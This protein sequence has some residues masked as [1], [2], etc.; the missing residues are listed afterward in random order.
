MKNFFAA[1]DHFFFANI[2]ARGFGLMRMAWATVTG[3][4]FFFQWKS[5]GY[6]YGNAGLL[7]GGTLHTVVRSTM[8]FTLLD[9]VQEPNAVFALY[10]LML[11]CLLCTAIG[12]LPRIMM[13]ASTLLVFS[14]H[15]G[16]PLLLGGGDTVLRTVGFILCIAPT[17]DA[18]SLTRALR[19]WPQWKK[20]KKLPHSDT[21]S[22]WPYRLLL[23]QLIIIY[24]TSL[25]YKLLGTTWVQGSAVGLSLMHPVFSRFPEHIGPLLATSWIVNY[26]SLLWE[27]AWLLLLI[28]RPM[29]HLMIPKF[30]ER[31]S[32]KRFVML[33]GIVYHGMII[34][35]MDAG[36]F[37]FAIFA[38]YCGL[39]LAEDFG[40][41]KKNTCD[42]KLVSCNSITVLY[43][44]HCNFCMRGIY[45]LTLCDW[46]G[47][48]KLV[49]YHD[50]AARKSAAPDLKLEDLNRTMHIR[51]AGSRTLTG[52]DAFRR[53]AHGLP[54]LWSLV[55]FLYVP[56]VPTIGRAIYDRIARKR[57]N[58]TDGSCRHHY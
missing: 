22:I 6:Y 45:V 47:T 42:L 44:G 40:T 49:N 4:Y 28:P 9:W 16:N 41:I 23:W 39:L 12:I 57:C 38:A 18:F 46:L 58:C 17:I 11:F 26:A 37:S 8:R 32:L 50:A 21:Q 43:D 13:I 10:L 30:M 2:D 55:P 14:F 54:P 1:I 31:Y 53:I 51:F 3:V 35:L 20:T 24:G 33:G 5:I 7:S 34:L 27:A 25:W 56:G 52:F 48:L 29:R 19:N 36:S 15:E